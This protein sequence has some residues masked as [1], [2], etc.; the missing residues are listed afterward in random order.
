MNEVSIASYTRDGALRWQ[1]HSGGS[2]IMAET[3]DAVMA[4]ALARKEY[5]RLATP[6]RL[7]RWDGDAGVETELEVQR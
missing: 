5:R 4:E 6:K 1:P 3:Q 7:T 2:P